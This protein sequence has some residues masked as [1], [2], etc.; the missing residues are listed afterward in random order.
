VHEK[1]DKAGSET[2]KCTEKDV[3]DTLELCAKSTEDE[4]VHEVSLTIVLFDI[5]F[6]CYVF[7]S[8]VNIFLKHH[9]SSGKRIQPY[10]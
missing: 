4:R 7:I 2:L 8:T 10:S 5:I 6:I 1:V 3:N 9:Y